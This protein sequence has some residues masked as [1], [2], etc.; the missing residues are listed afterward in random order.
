MSNC[1][2]AIPSGDEFVI[3]PNHFHGVIIIK[4][5]PKL[6]K[7]NMVGTHSRASL[8]RHPRTL[9]AIIAGFKSAA[10][11]RI[12]EE[13]KMPRAPVWQSRFYD[14]IIRNDKELNNIRDYISN[15]IL[16]WSSDTDNPDNIPL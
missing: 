15:N 3:M 2:E 14:R 16:K 13:R 8:R 11:K 1:G 12:N 4:D 7:E 5:E 10:T 6:Q 9:G